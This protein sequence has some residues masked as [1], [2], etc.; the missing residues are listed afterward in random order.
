[1]GTYYN[2][3]YNGNMALD[4]GREELHDSYN[5]DYWKVLPIERMQIMPDRERLDEENRN[6]KFVRAEEKATKSIQKHSMYMGG[7]E[8]NPQM[9][10]A[11]LLLGKSRYY[12]Q[13]FIPAKDAFSFI[14]NHYR[15]SST[16]NEVKVWSEKVNTRLG[17]YQEATENLLSLISTKEMEDEIRVLALTS[18][19][20]VYLLTEKSEQSI[21]PI[22]QAIAITEDNELKDVFTILKDKFT[23]SSIKKI[24]RM[25]LL[26]ISLN[27]IEKHHGHIAFM[28][29]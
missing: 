10:E 22:N 23:K 15:K 1:M 5:E 2:T 14:L 11:F 17:Y 20:E 24:A 8:F 13:R 25:L 7:K 21:Q 19:A 6:E 3:L 12:D 9:D 29:F 28:L 18:L 26:K 4:E 27:S 16:I